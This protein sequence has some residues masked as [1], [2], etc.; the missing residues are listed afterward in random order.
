[1]FRYFNVYW[2]YLWGKQDSEYQESVKIEGNLIINS[3]I[4]FHTIAMHLNSNFLTPSE[5]DVFIWVIGQRCRNSLRDRCSFQI[6]FDQCW[7]FCRSG[8]A[9][10]SER[11]LS[12]LRRQCKS[13][14]DTC[15]GR[16]FLSSVSITS[17]VA[18]NWELAF[19]PHAW[20]SLQLVK[21]NVA[22]GIHESTG[23]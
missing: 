8:S 10:Q 18:W 23:H 2:T 3:Y 4:S 17:P 12:A 21:N 19:F 16:F 6:K 20:I 5:R 22:L 9:F 11:N 15:K 14:V 1:M 7:F 13:K